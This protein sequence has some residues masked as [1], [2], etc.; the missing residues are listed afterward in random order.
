MEQL[1]RDSL[2]G[3]KRSINQNYF[4]FVPH[5]F[6][7][8]Q[9]LA[10]GRWWLSHVSS[11]PFRLKLTDPDL[12]RESGE[13]MASDRRVFSASRRSP[14]LE[15]AGRRLQLVLY[16]ALVGML[17]DYVCA[18][19]RL[20]LVDRLSEPRIGSPVEIHLE[21]KLISQD[22]AHSILE[23][24]SIFGEM[25]N[26]W[27]SR[28]WRI[29]EV[30][31]G[32][33][34]LA[35]VM[36]ETVRCQYVIFDIPPS[37]YVSQWYLSQLYPDKKIF[38]FRHFD[39]FEDIA[40]ELASADIAFFTANQIELVPS[41]YFDVT[42]NISSLHE[43]KP[44]QIDNMLSQMYRVTRQY[45]YLKQYKEYVNPYDGLRLLED[46]YKLAPGWRYRHYRDDPVNSR[47]F[48]TLIEADREAQPAH[49]GVVS[50]QA[51]GNVR[52]GPTVSILLANF[53]N[54][55]YLT[56][57][58]AAICGQ[59]HQA[60][61]VLIVDDGSTDDSIAA[62]ER[63]A[64][65]FTNIRLLRNVRNRGQVA[66]IQRALLE[67]KGDYVVWAASDDL[68]LPHFL[69]RS[70]AALREHPE[71]GLCF[72]RL[73]VFVDGTSQARE[74][75]ERTDG[76]AFDYG[77]QAHYISPHALHALLARHYLWISGN[78][79]LAKRSALLEMGG[80]EKS[81]RWHSDWFCFYV[82]ALRYGACVIPET[83]ALMRERKDTYSRTGMEDPAQQSAV[84][85]AIFDQMKSP[86]YRD[87]VSIFRT[88]PTLL[89]L[90]GRRALFSACW[91]VRH[92]D[93]A[94]SLVGWHAAHERQVLRRLVR[95]VRGRL[96]GPARRV[97]GRV[98]RLLR[99]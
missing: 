53:N 27:Q 3:F 71:A 55:E 50:E 72:S 5:R 4:N 83:L 30:G 60:L 96:G 58:L 19:D 77:T 34:R 66:S 45:V 86:K 52:R 75:N 16:R 39:R 63:Y 97:R 25:P 9:I 15:R 14:V 87:L 54:V 17:W 12:D 79:V 81:L 61:E 88:R 23:C 89:S 21:Q 99:R 36:L 49:S 80:F 2:H 48:E 8:P 11:T 10:L 90:F 29:A 44:E 33:G 94:R 68:L 70:L 91:N 59:T 18:H 32:Y 57:S 47:F 65:R 84:L 93:I 41:S 38:R 35:H 42:I 85:Q 95:K 31:A 6:R 78:T 40:R 64:Q 7:D 69:E 24:N 82:I 67:A 1:R 37:L 76:A 56:T 43:L 26:G 20:G 73:A 98:R 22:L 13:L 51:D 74:F 46:S 92:W 28:Y 62:I